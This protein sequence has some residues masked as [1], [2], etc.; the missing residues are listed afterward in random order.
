MK[1]SAVIIAKN[2]SA[3]I[4]DA[5]ASVSFADEI[6]V[7]DSE[8]ADDTVAIAEEMGARVIVNPWMGFSKQKQFGVDHAS[9]DWIL[10]IDADERVSPELRHELQNLR[11]DGDGEVVAFSVPRLS[12]Y[13]GRPIL[14][15]GWYPDR[16]VRLFDR[17]RAKWNGRTIHESVET[18]GVVGKLFGNLF[19]YSVDDS[20][21]HHRMIGERYAPMSALAAFESGKEG[22]LLKIVTSPIAAFVRNYLLKAGFADGLPGFAICWFSAHHAFLKNVILWELSTGVRQPED[23]RKDSEHKGSAS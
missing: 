9:N 8:S 6:I 14:H 17:R 11:V 16:Q 4:R 15:C 13:L 19:H 21:H 2:E 5:I 20:S 3:K 1:L 22:S 7:I 18:D 23:I 10:S 12:F